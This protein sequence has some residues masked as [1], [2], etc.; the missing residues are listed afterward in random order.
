M[1]SRRSS[2]WLAR[3]RDADGHEHSRMFDRK[4]DA[5]KWERDQ[6]GTVDRGTHVA[7]RAGKVLVKDYA[8]T[9][10][11]A[12]L[13][14]RPETAR[15]VE[16]ILRIHIVPF[17]GERQMG[18]VTR[19][20]IQG[21]VNRWAGETQSRT[22]KPT[23]PTTMQLWYSYLSGIFK[24]AADDGVIGKTPCTRI[25]L[26]QVPSELVQPLT[27]TQVATLIE[28]VHADI[29]P[30]VVV[31]AGLGVRVSE[32]L[33]ITR[34]RVRFLRREVLIDR[35]QGP[36]PPYPLVPLKNSRFTPSRV[37]PA[38]AFLLDSVS[39]LTPWEDGRLFTR[40][41]R[42]LRE[43]EVSTA[44]ARAVESAGLP[45][46][47]TFHDLRHFYAS[48]LIDAGE[49]VPVVAARLGDSQKEILRTY[50]H[51]FPDSAERTRTIMDAVFEDREDQTRTR[52]SLGT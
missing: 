23:A 4:R 3:Y 8:E 46:G 43:R 13:H 52:R 26:P 29:R 44:I 25:R 36:K 1:P 22:G 45:T 31:G 2:G 14:H 32:A 30:V 19:T 37:V 27:R 48:T 24:S 5:D 28:T 50:S 16:S 15:K 6:K 40:N 17:L 12:Q 35:Q 20:D 42:L 7:P 9:W 38:P 39:A 49:S 34:D 11:T 18:G 51:L 47:T 33:G 10:R 41:G 21:L